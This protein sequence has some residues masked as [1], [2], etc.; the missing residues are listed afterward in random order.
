MFIL[1]TA[2]DLL[3]RVNCEGK[4][5]RPQ[6]FGPTIDYRTLDTCTVDSYNPIYSQVEERHLYDEKSIHQSG[7]T[8][9]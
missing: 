8:T 1:T 9:L 7:E 6:F 3:Q 2:E 4:L 5:S